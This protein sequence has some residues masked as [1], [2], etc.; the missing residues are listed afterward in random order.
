M[1]TINISESTRLIPQ[2]KL[3][4]YKIS[5]DN[6][7]NEIFVHLDAEDL[8]KVRLVCKQ[9]NTCVLALDSG[10]QWTTG[11]YGF[12]KFSS[13]QDIVKRRQN[14]AICNRLADNACIAMGSA[15]NVLCIP[16]CSS[17]CVAT[18]GYISAFIFC[19][20]LPKQCKDFDVSSL[21]TNVAVATAVVYL[22]CYI[23]FTV[24]NLIAFCCLNSIPLRHNQTVLKESSQ[25]VY[26]GV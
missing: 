11:L 4:P 16:A 8:C 5:N 23:F 13:R 17:C 26:E 3:K 14:K 20:L 22:V 24:L 7:I 15:I 10:P 12:Y 6:L 21:H 19:N 9:W 25:L 18:I 2:P 1:Y